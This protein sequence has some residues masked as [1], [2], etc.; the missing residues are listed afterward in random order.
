MGHRKVHYEAAFEDYLRTKGWPFIVV[1]EAKRAA[2][3]A[4]TLKSFDLL[5]YRPD[6]PN[7][8]VD[9]K[10]R[11]FPD[12]RAGRARGRAWENWVTRGDVEG[13]RQWQ[14]VF[15]EGF[16]AAVVFAYW[17][18]GPPGGAP[19]EDVAVFR[20][21]SYAFAGMLLEDYVA[22]ARPRSR[23]WQTISAPSAAL[24]ERART[25]PELL[26]LGTMQY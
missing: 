25:M 8:L 3:G 26:G 14:G 24:A 10:G 22:M 11:K 13:L 9:V 2:F 5:V 12:T 16:A 7:L 20:G 17:L 15:G 1:D 18:Q 6:G 19:F 4:V 23:R 21:R